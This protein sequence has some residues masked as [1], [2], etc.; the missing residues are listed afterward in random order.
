MTAGGLITANG[1]IQASTIKIG[2]GGLLKMATSTADFTQ[3]GTTDSL[4]GVATCISLCG[5]THPTH[6]S[7]ILYTTE[8]TG[9]HKFFTVSGGFITEKMRIENNGSVCIGSTT[10]SDVD[11][12][13]AFAI[14]NAKL[15]VRGAQS[16]GATCD[17]V[18]R[19]GVEGE[20]NGKARLWL[21]ADASYSSYIQSE[22]IGSGNTQLT[23]GTA[24]GNTLPTQRMII[25]KDGY[26]GIG[27]TPIA[28]YSLTTFSGIR[29][30]STI[31]APNASIYGGYIQSSGY[32]ISRSSYDALLY[33]DGGGMFM[34]FG[35]AGTGNSDFLE[36]SA[37]NSVT[38][39]NSGS[40]RAIYFRSAGYTWQFN[41][42]TSVNSAGSANW[43]TFSDQRIKE[44]IK[45]SNLK[46]CYDN[47]K[48]I[49]LYRFNY[50]KELG[51]GTQNDRTQLGF[52][53]QQVNQLYPK[54]VHRNKQR[55]EDKREIPDL[56]TINIDQINFTLF[57]AVKQLM[58]VV[59]KQSK[60]I[61]KLEEMLEIIDDDEVEN[62]ADE[63]YERIVCDEVDIDT[64]EPS[65][66]TPDTPKEAPADIPKETP[67]D[68]PMHMGI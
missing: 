65:E 17:V 8:Q 63:P 39:F 25:D 34:R 58:K 2:G 9:K 11:N 10:T 24:T 6:P 55:L 49:N 7:S 33:T 19:G 57:G 38:N 29:I 15:Y 52:I 31:D 42:N 59:E 35:S 14:P 5:Y 37:S 27:T 66:P 45:K 44:N 32:V 1:G 26:V 64:I 43:N 62:D 54:S 51:K 36:I 30:G 22:H 56:A 47:V 53:A 60:R 4:L 13:T 12:N 50:K 16:G 67:T 20:N 68:I 23:F 48:N 18:F 46:I 21:S 28:G 40:S 41:Q 3:I 61:K